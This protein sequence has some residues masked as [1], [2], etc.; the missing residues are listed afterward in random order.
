MVFILA[1]D[2]V[3]WLKE[4]KVTSKQLK[5]HESSGQVRQFDLHVDISLIVYN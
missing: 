4:T 2:K 1:H 5:R 3:F